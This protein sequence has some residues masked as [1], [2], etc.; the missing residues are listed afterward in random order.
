MQTQLTQEQQ[1]QQVEL[2]IEQAREA[3]AFGEAIS[4]LE[5]NPDFKKVVF[6]G[7][8]VEEAARTVS[9]LAEPSMQRPESQLKLA[10]SLRGIS[11]FKQFLLAHKH[12]CEQLRYE[13]SQNQE[14]LDELREE[15]VVDDDDTAEE[16]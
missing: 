5:Q 12:M 3:L 4:R 8:F 7:Y 10:H 15:A 11:E 6:D 13:M 1:I 16:A 14:L 9:L 2:S